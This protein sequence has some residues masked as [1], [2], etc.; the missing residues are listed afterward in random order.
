MESELSEVEV[1]RTVPG[2]GV[3]TATAL[4]GFVGEPTRFP[5]ARH[6]TS[7]L[8]LTPR[9][10]SSGFKRRMGH[11]S[12]R[13][14]TYVRFLLLHGARAARSRLDGRAPPRAPLHHRA[15]GPRRSPHLTSCPRHPRW[16][17][18]RPAQGGADT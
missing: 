2:I 4:A 1:L 10:S 12:K 17:T 7:Y 9:E 3:L 6:F 11:I 18:V 8:G 13:G 16:R 5:S 15:P 14:N